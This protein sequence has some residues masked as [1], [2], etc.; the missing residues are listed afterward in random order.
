MLD[1]TSQKKILDPI[2]KNPANHNCA[3][4]NSVAPTCTYLLIQGPLSTS[5]CSSAQTVRGHIEALAPRS[6]E[7]G[8]PTSTN[9][10]RS[11]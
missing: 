9:G 7:C 8:Q 11:G 4:C 5:E 2:L 1:F 10:S 3:D 6:P